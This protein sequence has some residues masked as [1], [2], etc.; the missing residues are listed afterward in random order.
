MAYNVRGMSGSEVELALA[1]AAAEGW[2]PGRA[3]AL[4]FQ[5]AD[6]GGFLI[7]HVEDEPAAVISVVRYGT[8]FGFL[9]LYI[10]APHLRGR[11][12]GLKLWQSG[13]AHLEG[14]T[15]GL[16]GVVAQQDKYRRSGFVY[17]WP[18]HRFG[19]VIEGRDDPGLRDARTLPFAEL[20][21]FD[22]ALFPAARDSFLAAWLAM[23]ESRTLAL[24][25]DGEIVGLGTIRRC[26]SG[27][28]IGPLHA[29]DR[30]S[31]ER[32]LLA[33]AAFA[34]GEELFLDVPGANA[35][36]MRMAEGFGLT[37]RFETARMY[38]GVAPGLPLDQIYG[39]TSFELG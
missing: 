13:L 25:R 20:A 37:Q 7:G 30:H 9:G 16:D 4:P 28:K 1:W 8:D 38:R 36:A 34:P 26:L 6:P 33:L 31:A 22:A 12:Y 19:G 2:N 10:V 23:P 27:C 35:A 15:V 5:I 24:M 11:G 3:D 29:R 39:I 21:R 18:N 14:R 17:A 32:L